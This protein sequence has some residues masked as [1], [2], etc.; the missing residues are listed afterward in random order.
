M[1]FLGRGWS[2]RTIWLLESGLHQLFAAELIA[3]AS[4]LQRPLLWFYTPDDPSIRIRFPG[5]DELSVDELD[6]AIGAG[7]RERTA[8]RLDSLHSIAEE[9]RAN[10]ARTR[11]SVRQVARPRGRQ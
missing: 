6:A 10:I 1:P 4:V 2:K 8:A 9:I 5:G 3:F 11:D 7:E